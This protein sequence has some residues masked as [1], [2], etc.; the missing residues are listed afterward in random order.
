ME[1]VCHIWLKLLTMKSESN[2]W[3]DLAF[4]SNKN[5]PELTRFIEKDVYT[6]FTSNQIKLVCFAFEW[7][8]WRMG[9]KRWKFIVTNYFKRW[10][11]SAIL[12]I[13]RKLYFD[14]EHDKFLIICELWAS[15]MKT[16][17]WHPLTFSPFI[18][19]GKVLSVNWIQIS[20]NLTQ[21]SIQMK[22]IGI[23][24][25]FDVCLSLDWLIC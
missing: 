8:R 14:S 11:Q 2:F 6:A 16:F 10:S 5:K 17:M 1:E 9:M 25:H 7:I 19:F 12:V 3:L 24:K 21:I 23:T 18:I 15:L 22:G 20:T 13:A 4:L